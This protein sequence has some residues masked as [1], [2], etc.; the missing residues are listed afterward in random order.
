VSIEL[1]AR[2]GFIVKAH[3]SIP[4]F[5]FGLSVL[6][7]VCS[8][9]KA[10]SAESL[11]SIV[12]GSH[13]EN[14]DSM[15]AGTSTP[16]NWH[17]GIGTSANLTKVTVNDGS[18]GPSADVAGF[19]FGLTFADPDRA[20]GTLPASGDRNIELRLRNNTGR[21]IHS[22]TVRYDGE[23]WR[24][25]TLV[26]PTA[27]VLRYSADGIDYVDMG[28]VF[29]FTSPRLALPP[30]LQNIAINGNEPNNRVAGIGGLYTPA[31]PVPNGAIIY[32]RWFDAD[33]AGADPGLAIDNFSFSVTTPGGPALALRDSSN[34]AP[35][36][37]LGV[38]AAG[39]APRIGDLLDPGGWIAN[40]RFGDAA[41]KPVEW[42]CRHGL[43]R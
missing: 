42:D 8:G 29:N 13:S 40:C 5:A 35:N 37:W 1:L 10:V 6:L 14:F 12:S 24:I 36:S 15:G 23:Q 21:S 41:G 18:A 34:R 9:W 2:N 16:A 27:L 17:V 22:F 32:L 3:L 26:S 30:L 43:E 28:P 39:F 4:H 25:G 11:I 19:N 33:E 38:Q 20:L 31:T 7:P